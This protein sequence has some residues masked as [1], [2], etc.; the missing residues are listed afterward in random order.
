MS[1]QDP[2][3]NPFL[4]LNH[5]RLCSCLGDL[6]A[7]ASSSS[8]AAPSFFF[9]ARFANLSSAP[10][11]SSVA[12][13]VP[14]ALSLINAR[15]KHQCSPRTRVAPESSDAHL[16]TRFSL[17]FGAFDGK[18][19]TRCSDEQR[20]QASI[21]CPRYLC[22]YT[23]IFLNDVWAVSFASFYFW[24]TLPLLCLSVIHTCILTASPGLPLDAHR[25]YTDA[26]IRYAI[27]TRTGSP[28]RKHRPAASG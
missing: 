26:S 2:M 15:G 23:S 21:F 10:R 20:F 14:A 6:A 12:S 16:V 18:G 4:C 8:P 27:V 24:I 5:P 7:R 17:R 25:G 3:K 19:V 1:A 22:M 9:S 13:R 28:H 11:V